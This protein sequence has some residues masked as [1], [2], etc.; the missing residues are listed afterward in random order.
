[1]ILPFFNLQSPTKRM[2]QFTSFVL[3]ASLMDHA[4]LGLCGVLRA[5]SVA[6]NHNHL[7]PTCDQPSL[8]TV[9]EREGPCLPTKKEVWHVPST[10]L[11]QSKDT[12]GYSHRSR[13]LGQSIRIV[14]QSSGR[15]QPLKKV[16]KQ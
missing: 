14:T 8:S 12:T 7:S 5:G 13:K 4:T 11:P 10:I 1:M 16:M 6:T 9:G 15:I 2:T 3:A